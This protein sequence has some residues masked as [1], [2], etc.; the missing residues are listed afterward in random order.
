M[1]TEVDVDGVPLFTL[2]GVSLAGREGRLRLRDVTVEIPDRAVTVVVGASGSG[3][4]SLLRLC[5]RLEAPDSG[6][7]CFRGRN[8][9][10]T[11]PRRHRRR[12]GMLFQ[13]PVTFPGTGRDNLREAA[14]DADDDRLT[15]WLEAADL[16]RSFLDRVA[17]ELSGGQAQR[18]CLA[19]A[20]ATEPEVLLADEA[21]SA[22]D[23]T[24]TETIERLVAELAG[25]GIP[26]VWVTHD[27]DQARRLA[28]HLVVVRDGAVARAGPITA[29]TSG[30]GGELQDLLDPSPPPGPVDEAEEDDRGR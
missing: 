19:R 7:V 29:L 4:S 13:Q 25:R 28:D 21:T 20:L 3:K 18:L 24:A 23:R 10:E 26:V 8:L 9:T 5:N 22:L 2:T 1:G 15:G 16:D 11:D 30:A 17:D 14:P 12:V 27:L 6:V